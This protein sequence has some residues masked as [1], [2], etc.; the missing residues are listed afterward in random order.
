MNWVKGGATRAKIRKH[1]ALFAKLWRNFQVVAESCLACGGEVALEWPR[2]CAYWR[3]AQVKR[4]L[5][6]W[7]CMHTKLD[8][9]MFGLVSVQSAT[10]GTPLR[11]P[12]TIAST[13]DEF[14]SIGIT[15]D[16]S[17]R[18]VRTQG[19]DTSVTE[20]YTDSLADAIHSVWFRACRDRGQHTRRT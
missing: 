19:A 20:G 6:K 10:R 1:W 8:G 15:C 16:G 5:K 9:C 2:S 13:C 4:S 14:K 11:K 7:G 12:W 3:R 18:H 17:H